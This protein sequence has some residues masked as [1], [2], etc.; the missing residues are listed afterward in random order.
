MAT[1]TLDKVDSLPNTEIEQVDKNLPT[2]CLYIFTDIETESFLAFLILQIAAVT[3]EGHQ[4]NSFINPGRPLSEFC[5]NF[6]GFYF[7]KG[8][9]FRN[10]RLLPAKPVKQALE[11]FSHWISNFNRPVVLV[12]H[13]GFS[14][15]CSVLAKYLVRFNISIPTNLITVCDSLPYIRT[16]F[17][18]PE[19]RDHKL[20]TLASH[21]GLVH[22]HAHDALSDS[23]VLKQVC[24]AICKQHSTDFKNIFKESCR[25][26]S[27]YI[28]KILYGK[29]LQPLRKKKKRTS[30]KKSAMTEKQIE[31]TSVDKS[32]DDLIVKLGDKLIS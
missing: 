31:K 26:F 15:D 3:S 2:D 6:L 11:E 21:F 7:F 27:D 19:I 16:H 28:D 1:N 20:G 5:T 25:P 18:F 12:Y 13:N 23:L 14:F 10:G 24:E 29:P 17:K 4:F 32:V 30:K 9:L 8:R 22:E